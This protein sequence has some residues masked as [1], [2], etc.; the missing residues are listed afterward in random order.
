MAHSPMKLSAKCSA[1]FSPLIPVYAPK[2]AV[3][4]ALGASA[5]FQVAVAGL[6]LRHQQLPGTL[7]AGFKL[8]SVN[9]ETRSLSASSALV[10]CV[11]FNQQVNA[12]KLRLT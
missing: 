4:E 9:R 1:E 7:C 6:A 3:G 2:P 5:L 8:P 12:A 10:T 11:G